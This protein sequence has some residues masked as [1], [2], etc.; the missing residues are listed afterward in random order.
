MWKSRFARLASALADERG[1]IMIGVVV[2]ALLFFVQW[3]QP[4]PNGGATSIMHNYLLLWLI[5]IV[6]CMFLELVS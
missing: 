1:G 5:V 3:R 4:Q 2:T 6:I